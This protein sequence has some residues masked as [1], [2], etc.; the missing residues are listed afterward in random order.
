MLY[1]FSCILI[2]PLKFSVKWLVLSIVLYKYSFF[3]FFY[4]KVAQEFPGAPRGEY[5][6][7]QE[8]LAAMSKDHDLSALHQLGGVSLLLFNLNIYNSKY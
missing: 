5:G 3:I 2:F 7:H 8:E 1:F 6:V 4:F